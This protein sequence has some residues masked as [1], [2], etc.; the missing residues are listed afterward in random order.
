MKTVFRIIRNNLVAVILICAFTTLTGCS[1]LLKQAGG[2]G[3][4]PCKFLNWYI[5]G[6]TTTDIALLVVS[7][8]GVETGAGGRVAMGIYSIVDL[9]LSLVAD[10][11]ILPI[12]IPRQIIEC[13]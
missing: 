11:L 8:V 9:P 2:V 5:Y 3:S 6:G 12:S 4:N 13:S 10:T 7:L 1:T